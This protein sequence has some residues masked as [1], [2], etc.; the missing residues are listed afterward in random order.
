MPFALTF[1]R[2]GHVP[3]LW[4]QAWR[5]LTRL[6]TSVGVKQPVQQMEPRPTDLDLSLPPPIKSRY[7]VTAVPQLT[8]GFHDVH[9][10]LNRSLPHPLNPLAFPHGHATSHMPH[11]NA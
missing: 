8:V 4:D 10:T 9:H 6:M 2:A 3:E 5:E 1:A 11:R 7:N